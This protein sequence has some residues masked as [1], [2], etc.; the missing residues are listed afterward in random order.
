MPTI[1]RSEALNMV[2][3]RS[4]EVRAETT[5]EGFLRLSY[6]LAVKPWFGRLAEKVNLWDK[7]PMIKRLELDEMGTFVWECIDGER[8]VRQIAEAFAAHYGL[9][10]R[11]AELGVTAFI[12]NIGQR[13]LLGL[14]EPS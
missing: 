9:Q 5:A 2:P 8:S 10:P 1:P 11:E 14:R 13:G 12:K 4:T 7:R 3:V 6:P